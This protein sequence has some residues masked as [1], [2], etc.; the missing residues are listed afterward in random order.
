M[1]TSP[2]LEQFSQEPKLPSGKYIRD[3]Y[4]LPVVWSPPKCVEYEV[5]F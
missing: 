3:E 5:N 1:R 2:P 4:D